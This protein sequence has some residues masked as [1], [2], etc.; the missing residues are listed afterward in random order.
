MI[1]EYGRQQGGEAHPNNATAAPG[2][3]RDEAQVRRAGGT[4][5]IYGVTT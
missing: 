2:Q 5:S 4:L 1:H 3:L